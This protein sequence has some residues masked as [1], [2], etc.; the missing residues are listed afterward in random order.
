M[1]LYCNSVLEEIVVKRRRL[2]GED[3]KVLVL[4]L[5]EYDLKM[6]EERVVNGRRLQSSDVDGTVSDGMEDGIFVRRYNFTND[7]IWYELNV[8]STDC[9]D[10][11]EDFENAR[12]FYDELLSDDFF[13]S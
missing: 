8:N 12:L 3:E 4:R 2:N 13:Q 10:A 1:Q 9:Y 5:S 7:G 6:M 11:I